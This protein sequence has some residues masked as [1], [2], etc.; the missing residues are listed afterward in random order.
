MASIQAP[1][2]GPFTA[3][4]EWKTPI[5][6]NQQ[7]SGGVSHQWEIPPSQ[8]LQLG[9]QKVCERMRYRQS[10]LFFGVL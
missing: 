8:V 7:C 4:T 2:A 5:R 10:P 9:G 6:F 3:E 1:L